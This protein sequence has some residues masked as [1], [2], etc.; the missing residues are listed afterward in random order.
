MGTAG[1]AKS[2]ASTPTFLRRCNL[3]EQIL[4]FVEDV[5]HMVGLLLSFHSAGV[6]SRCIMLTGRSE[7]HLIH[8][9]NA[10]VEAGRSVH[11]SRLHQRVLV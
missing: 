10:S 2:Q 8:G 5:E 4:S 11:V 1:S 9:E 7:Q 3:K 6:G